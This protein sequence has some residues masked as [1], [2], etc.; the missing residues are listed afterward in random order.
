MRTIGLR[1][2]HPQEL[3]N[4]I[5]YGLPCHPNLPPADY[6]LAYNDSGSGRSA[7]SFCMCPGGEVI[8]SSKTGTGKSS[9]HILYEL[10]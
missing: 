8:L 10:V 7:Y 9:G 2:E 3:I 1:I 6:S 4:R 5:Q